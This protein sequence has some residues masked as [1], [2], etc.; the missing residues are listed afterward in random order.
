MPRLSE[1]IRNKYPDIY[2][3]LDDD[4]LEKF[5]IAKHPEYEDLIEKE[6]PKKKSIFLSLNP[7]S[8][9]EMIT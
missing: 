5:V 3:D 8:L 4:E 2:N 7:L 6:E 9:L 1:L